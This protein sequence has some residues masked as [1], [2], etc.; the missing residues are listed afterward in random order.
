MF[1]PFSINVFGLTNI[2]QLSI[3]F[4]F[5][6]RAAFINRARNTGTVSR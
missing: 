3:W 6:G 4:D 5:R 2:N 1:V